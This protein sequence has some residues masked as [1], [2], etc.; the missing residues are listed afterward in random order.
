M[1]RRVRPIDRLTAGGQAYQNRRES[2][3]DF[4][5][6]FAMVGK[7]PI[8]R[9]WLPNH[10][11]MAFQQPSGI[12]TKLI[13]NTLRGRIYFIEATI[14]DL[15]QK[16]RDKK[17]IMPNIA[18]MLKDE[19]QRL[20]KREIKSATSSLRKDNATLKR[21]VVELKRRL[22]KLESVDKRM[23]TG[24]EVER[25]QEAQV[26]EEQVK[27]ARITGRMI[28]AIRDRLRLSQRE[29]AILARVS[30]PAVQKWEHKGGRLALRDQSKAA[31]I[32]LRKMSVHEAQERLAGMK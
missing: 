6:D 5:S 9:S 2:Q 12:S 21:S 28:R 1:V 26:T 16:E 29:F 8:V 23:V 20:A 14:Q 32:G 31:L 22:A 15:P 18:K 19:I 27:T 7:P 10:E 25:S 13:G 17:N 11:V 24:Q 4:P 3:N 30:L